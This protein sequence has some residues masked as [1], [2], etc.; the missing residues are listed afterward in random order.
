M[1]DELRPS[2]TT[3]AVASVE[4]VDATADEDRRPGTYVTIRIDDPEVRWSA[5]RVAI[6][7]LPPTS[8]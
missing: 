4:F 5:G 3:G 8:Q 1:A 7:Y 2:E 6:R